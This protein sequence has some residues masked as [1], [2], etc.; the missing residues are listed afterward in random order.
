[1]RTGSS[2]E[3]YKNNILNYYF[4]DQI[5]QIDENELGASDNYGDNDNSTVDNPGQQFSM[6][7]NENLNQNFNKNPQPSN[8]NKHQ[9]QL[10]SNS[11]NNNNNNNNPT[12]ESTNLAK[13][14]LNHHNVNHTHHDIDNET[15]LS[16]ANAQ[17]KPNH[18]NKSIS[19]DN[20]LDED[21]LM[22]DDFLNELRQSEISLRNTNNLIQTSLQHPSSIQSPTRRPP[23]NLPPLENYDSLN[24]ISAHTEK[25]DNL[26]DLYLS[27][28][29]S[30]TNQ[31]APPP[32]LNGANSSFPS[33]SSLNKPNS[34]NKN[35]PRAKT[36]TNGG[37]M[38]RLING[39]PSASNYPIK[40]NHPGTALNIKI[41]IRFSFAYFFSHSSLILSVYI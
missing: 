24:K 26:E 39:K 16:Q 41:N 8:S 27:K 23:L 9:H 35:S 38:V 15:K 20:F 7:K 19:F 22:E 11:S 28:T 3:R 18:D 32:F 29:E 33:F 12:T 1:M 36:M 31:K 34:G 4:N 40:M 14:N 5:Y 37:D 30:Y 10:E 21:P 17:H 6:P 13:Y 25:S 2:T